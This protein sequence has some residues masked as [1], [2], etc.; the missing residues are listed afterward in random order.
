MPRAISWC[1]TICARAAAKS[2][3]L[4]KECIDNGHSNIQR[5]S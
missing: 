3:G 1:S 2:S 5:M 4:L